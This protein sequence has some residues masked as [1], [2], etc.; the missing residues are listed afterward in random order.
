MILWEISLIAVLGLVFGSFLNVCISR[1]PEG[2][3][4][5]RPRSHC[6]HCGATIPWYDNLPVISWILL[7][8]RCRQCKGLISWR[9]PLIE[10]GTAGLWVACW[11][12]FCVTNTYLVFPFSALL[13]LEQAI[14]CF[15][16]L[17]LAF[18]DWEALLLP[19]EFTWTGIGLGILWHLFWAW[20]KA[21]SLQQSLKEILWLF[22]RIMIAALIVLIIRWIYQL[23]RHR[24][25]MGLG[26][27]KLM[28]MLAAW[29]GLQQTLLVF[30]LA[31]IAGA[32]FAMILLFFHRGD[33]TSWAERQIPLGTFL[34]FAGIYAV[35]FG[36]ATLRWYEGFL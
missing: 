25:G 22:A 29:L 26:D 35:F 24:E 2:Q 31:V 6:M 18:M 13:A 20:L 5:V 19:D 11:L 3:S 27:V 21:T 32:V 28:A 14:F 23:V 15:L 4:I 33:Q 9:Y 8:A 36:P 7:R 34:C 10:I 12:V 1:L 16:L 30:F 17:G